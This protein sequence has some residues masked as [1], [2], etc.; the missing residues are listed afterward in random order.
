[1]TGPAIERLIRLLERNDPRL[2]RNAW[3]GGSLRGCLATQAAW[4]DSRTEELG[5]RAG[6]AWL[7]SVA[8][9]VPTRSKV[10]RDWDQA[11][12]HPFDAW[13]V[14]GRMLALLREEQESR[15]ASSGRGQNPQSCSLVS[16]V[17]SAR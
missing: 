4:N 14:R 12:E 13:Q 11:I 9:V 10:I 8:G 15:R 17:L 7:H 5:E 1:M 6:A 16:P 2:I 3:T